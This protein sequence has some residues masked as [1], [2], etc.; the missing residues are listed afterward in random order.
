MQVLREV[1]CMLSPKTLQ[2]LLQIHIKSIGMTLTSSLLLSGT[3]QYT[4][5]VDGSYDSMWRRPGTNFP[6]MKFFRTRH[7]GLDMTIH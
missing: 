1:I 7:D 2:Y 4:S 5:P 6:P 3:L